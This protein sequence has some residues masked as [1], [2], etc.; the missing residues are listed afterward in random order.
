MTAAYLPSMMTQRFHEL[1]DYKPSVYFCL[2]KL[3]KGTFPYFLVSLSGMIGTGLLVQNTS[4]MNALFQYKLHFYIGN[5]FNLVFT[6]GIAIA[7]RTIYSKETSQGHGRRGALRVISG[8]IGKVS[9]T[10]RTHRA[11]N[12]RSTS[13]W[14]EFII[15]LPHAVHIAIC[16]GFVHVVSWYGV[17]NQGKVVI[18][19]FTMLGITMK[20]LIQEA[21]RHYIL[22]KKI[23]GIRT[24]CL[25]VGLPTVLIDTQSRI[26]LL[27]TQTNSFLVA[28][29][30]AMAV[31]EMCLR[32]GKAAYVA[33]SIRRRASDLEAKILELSSNTEQ[34]VETS[35]S[36]LR[37]EFDLWKR[38]IISYHTAELTAD[39]YA[40]YIAIGCS[41][42]IIFWWSGHPFYP[43]LEL[44]TGGA[45]NPGDVAMWR[46]NQVAMLA[47]QF[48]VEIFVDYL[49]V[50]VEMAAG[51]D[52]ARIESRSTFLGV[53]FMMMAVLNI[54]ISSVVDT[55]QSDMTSKPSILSSPRVAALIFARDQHRRDAVVPHPILNSPLPRSHFRQSRRLQLGL[56]WSQ[57]AKLQIFVV[58]N[59]LGC[60]IAAGCANGCFYA[61]NVF[62]L[63]SSTQQSRP[64]FLMA[65]LIW[66]ISLYAVA[67]TISHLPSL[68]TQRFVKYPENKPNLWFCTKKLVIKSG[69]YFAGSLAGMVSVGLLVQNTSLMYHNFKYK[70]HFYLG[71]LS[72]II[73]TTGIMRV[74]KKIYYEETFQGRDRRRARVKRIHLTSSKSSRK[75]HPTQNYRF[76]SFWRDCLVKF[77]NVLLIALAGGYVHIVSWHRILDQGTAVILGFTVFGIVL[78]LVL[79]EAVRFYI[80]KKRI[81]SIRTMCI[82]V[83]VPTVLI[84]TQTRIVLLGTQTNTI[85]V[86]GTF[87]MAIAE[88][89]IRIAKALFVLWTIRRR[90]SA[91]ELKFQIKSLV[92][93]KSG[94]NLS[95]LPLKLEFESWKQRVLSYQSAEITADMYA[96]YIAIGCSQSIV[97]WFVGHPFYSALQLEADN[98]LSEA[99]FARWRFNQVAMLGFQFIVEILVDYVCVVLEMAIGMEFDRIKEAST[100]LG[101][102]FMTLAV[103]NINI[104]TAVYLY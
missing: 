43:A 24:M 32:A 30:V 74:A 97:F 86:S 23:R 91:L 57:A 65:T 75:V 78:K 67:M 72:S 39:M 83:G 15:Q 19:G 44:E 85:L 2:K 104:T 87:G 55:N 14:R 33:R 102:M 21:A 26:V 100:F 76:L 64:E 48:V 59:A 69:F 27:G 9:A 10:S 31:A 77:P 3:I 66:N 4:L 20:L 45:M 90:S 12:Y 71:D 101:V 49:C 6:A 25:L 11:P 60:V 95:S 58:R 42:S 99:H 68:V 61:G 46:F 35:A 29:T 92:T 41:Q 52:F 56:Q 84:D 18:M 38:Q 8:R 5:V 28:G 36:S 47:F 96:E 22:K 16:G 89:S 81:R 80:I 73:F 34:S 37:L 70:L 82:L 63:K 13:F 1:P 94:K 98:G 88:V 17:L 51:I 79:Q 50:V 54:N 103:L 40:E 62:S 7:A 93:E 53:V